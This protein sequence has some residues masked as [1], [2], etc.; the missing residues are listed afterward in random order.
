MEPQVV[1]L[2]SKYSV[3]CDKLFATIQRSGVDFSYL[4]LLCVDNEKI[5]QR[6]KNTEK[7]EINSV[8]C[9]LAIYSS[10]KVEKYDEYHAFKFVEDRIPPEEQ[11]MP[12]PR[13]EKPV[14]QEEVNEPEEDFTDPSGRNPSDSAEFEKNAKLYRERTS[15][16]PVPSRPKKSK[17]KIPSRMRP[18]IQE[19]NSSDQEIPDDDRYVTPVQPRRIR[20]D[21]N[22]YDEDENLFGGDLVDHRRQPGNTIQ[23]GTTQKERSDPHGTLSIS[24]KIKMEREEMDNQINPQARRP[25]DTRRS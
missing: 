18:I 23:H 10:G 14:V 7:L 2:Y 1:L 22:T 25:M 6:I 11:I 8:P 13:P 12:I 19:E 20:K 17:H 9:I 5:R 24:E 16:A 4:Q 3:N 21:E 15:E